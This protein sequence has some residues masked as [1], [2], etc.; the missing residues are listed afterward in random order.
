MRRFKLSC[1]CVLLLSSAAVDRASAQSI[2]TIEINQAIGVQ[3]NANLK[4]VAGKDTVVRAFMA[5]PVT[6]QSDQTSAAVSRDGLPIVTLSPNNYDRATGVVDFQCPSRAACGDWAAGSYQFD[7]TVNGAS[8]STAGTTYRFVERGKLRILAVPVKTNYNGTIL[9]VTGEDWKSLWKFTR[10]VYPVAYNGIT[11]TTRGEVDTSQHNIETDDGQREVWTALANLNPA[12]CAANNAADECFDKIIG[13]IPFRTGTYPDGTGQGY[14][15][16]SPA[17]IVVASDQDAAATVAH[18]IAHNFGIGD[19]YNGGSFACDANPT[20]DAFAGTAFGTGEPVSCM[21]GR[22][23][24]PDVSGTL[25]PA[26][27]HPYEVGGR[28]ALPDVAEYMGSGG[29]QEV[30]WTSQD[31]YDWIFDRLAP[32][33]AAAAAALSPQR[34]QPAAVGQQRHLEFSG[35]IGRDPTSSA[36]VDLDPWGSFLDDDATLVPDTTGTLMIAAVNAAGQQVATQA[37]SVAFD[38]PGGKGEAVKRLEEAPFEGAIRFPDGTVKFQILNGGTVLTEVPVSAN[39]PAVSSVS[40][41]GIGSVVNGVTPISWTATDADGDSLSYIVEYNPD[42]TLPGSDFEVL[43]ADITDPRLTEDF[44]D[45][46]GGSHAKIRVTASDGVNATSAESSEF[47]VPFKP[48]YVE[49]E[50]LEA[51]AVP[52]DEEVY[53]EVFVDDYQDDEI[54]ASRLVWTSDISG[55][56]G[57]GDFLALNL[58]PGTHTITV[59]ATNSGGLS[60]SETVTVTVVPVLRRLP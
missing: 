57:T 3:K 30:F 15:F 17:N 14:T 16:G 26:A 55:R 38:I 47:Q 6:V 58:V 7:V 4:F 37:L 27:H 34:I 12:Q 33:A 44:S 43:D 41:G 31:A 1:V 49:I 25:V 48:P 22:V 8:A 54:P 46:P 29:R 35:F 60:T 51:S 28:G 52:E 19:A 39:A 36:D 23:Q 18:E 5:E 2:A 10:D 59:T 50:P 45:L 42:V 56:L 21:A 53:L 11:W 20:P 9:S 24:L 40:L 13:F 32:P